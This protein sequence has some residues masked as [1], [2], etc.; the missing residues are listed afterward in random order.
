[1]TARVIKR[2]SGRKDVMVWN[3]FTIRDIGRPSQ[4]KSYENRPILKSRFVLV[5]LLHTR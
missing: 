1:M 5:H 2:H 3:D 4:V